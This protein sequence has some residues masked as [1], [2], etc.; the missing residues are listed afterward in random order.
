[1]PSAIFSAA[2]GPC[3]GTGYNLICTPGF[4]LVLTFIIS[5]ITAPV[6]EVKTPIVL[7]INGIFFLCDSANN[8]S[9]SSFF[10][11]SSYAVYKLPSPLHKFDRFHLFQTQQ[12]CLRPL[13]SFHP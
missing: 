3:T 5:L 11:N 10:F 9:C 8:P 2:P 6:L 1:M 12:H 7:G 13:P 4:L